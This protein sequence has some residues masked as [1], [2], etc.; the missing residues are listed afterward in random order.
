MFTQ[1]LILN[2][3]NQLCSVVV[4]S[5][6]SGSPLH[7]GNVR[8]GFLGTGKIAQA[9]IL[10]LIKKEK[11]KPEQIYVSDS[12]QKYLNYLRN[13]NPLFKVIKQIRAHDIF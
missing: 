7:N 9:V 8:M 11:L 1:K 13:K 5:S 10:G 3:N 4:R 12:N 6:S 2:L